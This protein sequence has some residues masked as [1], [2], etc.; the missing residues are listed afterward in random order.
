MN[1]IHFSLSTHYP[2][3]KNPSFPGFSALEAA[4][5]VWLNFARYGRFVGIKGGD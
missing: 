1:N 4:E 2:S 5:T 3:E